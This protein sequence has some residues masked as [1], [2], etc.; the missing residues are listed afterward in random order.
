MSEAYK[1]VDPYPR[2]ALITPVKNK[3]DDRMARIEKRPKDPAPGD[4]SDMAAWKKFNC[5][6]SETDGFAVGKGKR[7]PFVDTVAKNKKF[8]PGPGKFDLKPALYAR[9]STSPPSVKIRRH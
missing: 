9:L 8:N 5:K 1:R 3:N 6:K 4:I 7:E 2:P